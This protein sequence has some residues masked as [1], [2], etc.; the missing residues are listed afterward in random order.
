M[1]LLDAVSYLL[2]DSSHFFGSICVPVLLLSGCD[3]TGNAALLWGVLPQAKSSSKSVSVIASSAAWRKLLEL[4]YVPSTQDHVLRFKRGDQEG[5][6]ICNMVL[7]PVFA[8]A[9]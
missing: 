7:P 3:S 2:D 5:Y 9:F 6:D 8:P 4:F 1:R